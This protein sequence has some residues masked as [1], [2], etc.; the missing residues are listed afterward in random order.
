MIRR[1]SLADLAPWLVRA[2]ASLVASFA[3]GVV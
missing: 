2:G 3:R 1:K